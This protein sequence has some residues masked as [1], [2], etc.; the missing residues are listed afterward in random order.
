MVEG[1]QELPS[2]EEDDTMRGWI[3]WFQIAS[4]ITLSDLEAQPSLEPEENEPDNEDEDEESLY[5]ADPEELEALSR[6]SE[7]Y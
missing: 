2:D 4:F 7:K 1:K 6:M 3:K 5:G